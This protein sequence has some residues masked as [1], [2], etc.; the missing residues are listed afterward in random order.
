[1]EIDMENGIRKHI[2]ELI[3][4]EDADY[5]SQPGKKISLNAVGYAHAFIMH[6]QNDKRLTRSKNML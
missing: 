6:M 2:T 1:M 5:Q 4:L 3:H